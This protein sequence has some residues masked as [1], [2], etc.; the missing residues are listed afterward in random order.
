MGSTCSRR[1]RTD[2]PPPQVPLTGPLLYKVPVKKAPP[3]VVPE[4][5]GRPKQPSWKGRKA[6]QQAKP[7]AQTPPPGLPEPAGPPPRRSRRARLVVVGHVDDATV[8]GPTDLITVSRGELAKAV[9]HAWDS[10]F[11][12]RGHETADV[13]SAYLSS[14]NYNE[15]FGHISEYSGPGENYYPDSRATGDYVETQNYTSEPVCPGSS[16]SDPAP[17]APPEPPEPEAEQ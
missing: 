8:V 1:R 15:H 17:S 16:S 7:P 2:P 5:V 11:A 14:Q 12:E 4:A 9:A 3:K 10:G 6:A 13:A